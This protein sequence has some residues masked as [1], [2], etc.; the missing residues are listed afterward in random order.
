M[1]HDM[2]QMAMPAGDDHSRNQRALVIS[3]ILTGVY[4]VVELVAGILI[5]ASRR[6]PSASLP[7]RAPILSGTHCGR[8]RAIIAN[9]HDLGT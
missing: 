2:S 8:G 6:D 7:R 1:G 9:Q 5:G 3:A 4:F